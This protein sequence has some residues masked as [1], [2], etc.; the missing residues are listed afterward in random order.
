MDIF[1]ILLIVGAF[2]LGVILA[3]ILKK[4]GNTNTAPLSEAEVDNID[5]NNA[6][7]TQEEI[8][9]LEGLLADEKKA[10]AD[11]IKESSDE[12]SKLKDLLAEEKKTHA[13]VCQ[14]HLTEVSELREQLKVEK[15]KTKA[16]N[17]NES[18][19]QNDK[20]EDVKKK[21]EMLLSEAKAQCQKLDIE[22]KN[23]INAGV[24]ES[25]KKRLSEIDKL[26]KKVKDLQEELEE[27]EDDIS[28]LKKKLKN[29]EIDLVD[30][31]DSLMSERKTSKQLAESISNV[32]QQ[33]E[34][35]IQ[36]LHLKAG[37]LNFIQEVLSAD[38]Y[39]N[40]DT[41]ALNK[42]IDFIESFVKGQFTDVSSYFYTNYRLV[43]DGVQYADGF[44]KIKQ[45]LYDGFEQWA[46]AKR[47]S[48]LDGK[49][50]IAFVGEFSAGKTSI[51]NRILSQDDPSIPRLPVSAKATTAI[52]TYIAG[53]LVTDYTFVSGDGRRKKIFEETFK[54]V[55]KEILDQ[56]K[57]V[58]SLIKYFV[59]EY[60]N[61]NL[62]GLSILDTPGFNSND[63]EDRERTI[64]VINECDALF[65]VFDVNAGT[66]N[67]SSISVI[68]EKLNKPLYV[69][70][71]K[72]DTKSDSEVDKVETLI[73]KT[74]ADEGLMV[75]AFIRF[76]EKAPLSAIMNPI[77]GVN[78]ISIRDTFIDDL[79]SHLDSL[80][81]KLGKEYKVLCDKHTSSRLDI[82]K[83]EQNYR[84]CIRNLKKDCTTAGNIPQ[85]V[86]HTFSKDRFEMSAQDGTKLK[87]TLNRISEKRVS[88]L[89]KGFTEC[90]EKSKEYQDIISERS[91]VKQDSQK[92]IECIDQYNKIVKTL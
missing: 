31:Q 48:W 88:E 90:S 17:N 15:E 9:R 83:I 39:G 60:K 2:S 75:Q 3:L 69:V 13:N 62:N 47:K 52:P 86:E 24:D 40:E 64:D 68:K 74:L 80:Y 81:K 7:A 16:I 43:W 55:S 18:Q 56:L 73:K 33:L 92:L 22:L 46:S 70:I 41:K 66:V 85:W 57:G 71:N 72:V 6:A 54:K 14:E 38:E 45:N 61:P 21:Y 78:K 34:E 50:T 49:T 30:L 37:S 59:M 84:N 53:G 4:S 42:N 44:N 63:K 23:A 76:S 32:K 28:D 26:E 82:E 36:E 1:T 19:I 79:R 35:K 29:K 8:V 27:S 87:D 12:I 51:V 89:E 65:W 58:S 25:V 77:I 91:K 10:F 20:I 5:K 67:R 11:T